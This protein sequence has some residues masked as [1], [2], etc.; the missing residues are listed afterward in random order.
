MKPKILVVGSL[1]LDLVCTCS[2]FP[3][4][5]ETKLGLDFSMAPGGKGA[6]QAMQAALLGADVS[7]AGKVGKD[8]FGKKLVSSLAGAGADVSMIRES[9]TRPS[10]VGSIQI[11]QSAEGSANR[12]LVIPGANMDI[13]PEDL[14]PVL[15]RLGDYRMVILQLEIPMEINEL[16][17]AAA[18]E[19]GVPVM[20]NSAP[21]APLSDEL[22]R[23]I[24][25]IS[26]N[27]HEA[28][29]LT[30][31]RVTDEESASAAIAALLEKG[32]KNVIIT[33][34]DKGAAFG[35]TSG[36]LTVP[37]AHYGTAVDPTAAGDSFVGAYC[38][39]VC[40]GADNR[41]ALEFAAH[42]A[43]ITVCRPGA[44]PSLPRIEEVL[45]FMKS[46]GKDISVFDELRRG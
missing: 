10:A 32:V 15:D 30:G 21:S 4:K 27:E 1:V 40:S 5:G 25:Y 22:L 8:D 20:L 13:H 9:E 38:T 44:Q 43:A 7:M 42:A 45:D 16:V 39:A 17:A 31:I 6:N 35:N 29:D 12:I 14:A 18:Y 24:T 34:G 36:F 19:K 26:P 37:C 2:S 41:S 23:H 11:E 3:Q 28:Y 46:C 33:M